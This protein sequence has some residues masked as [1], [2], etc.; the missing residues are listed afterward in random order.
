M[1]KQILL[2]IVSL[3]FMSSCSLAPKYTQPPSPVPPQWPQ[4]DAYKNVQPESE[5][6]T[7]QELSLQTFFVDEHLQKVIEIALENNRDLRLAALNVERARA[8]YGIQRAELL[9]AI[10]AVGSGSKQRVPA[11]LSSS[12]E[13]MTM[14]Q[15][16]I[17]LG[18]AAWEIDFFGRMRSLKDQALEAYLATDA[19]R[20]SAQIA[21]VSETARVYLTLAADRERL[22][23]AQS[24]LESQQNAY[25]LVQKRHGAGLATELD[26]LRAQTPVDTARRDVARYRQMLAQDQNALNLLAGY[27]VPAEIQP[28]DLSSIPPFQEISPGLSSETLLQRPDILQAEH[29]LKGSYAFIGA[30]RAA[31]FPRISLTTS[32]GTASDDLSGLFSSGSGAWNFAPQIVMPIFDARTWA[33]LQVSKADKEIVLTLYEKAIQTAFR[34]VADALAVQGT[35]DRQVSSQESLVSAVEETYRLSVE[36]YK[37]GIDNYLG[38]LYT[39]QSQFAAQQGLVSLRLAKLANQVRLYA[40]LGGGAE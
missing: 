31:F 16:N 19:A 7:V 32:F 2:L 24:T 30:A 1:R 34:E 3:V 27:M 20:R 13:A 40:V 39:Q 29:R 11:D 36:R 37:A 17:N 10:D 28:V 15:Y 35:I 22:M 14:E 6:V 9:P 4:G 5:T 12:G 8:L 25:N 18:I 23:L 21:L 38:V 26:L 33:A